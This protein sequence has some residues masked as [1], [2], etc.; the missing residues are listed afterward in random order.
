MWFAGNDLNAGLGGDIFYQNTATSLLVSFEGVQFHNGGAGGGEINAQVEVFPDGT[1]NTCWSTGDLD[2]NTIIAGAGGNTPGTVTFPPPGAPFTDAAPPSETATYPTNQCRCFRQTAIGGANGD[3][4]FIRWEHKHHDSFHGECDLVLVNAQSAHSK[5]EVAVHLRT[6]IR[7]E[8]YS[9]I[10]AIGIAIGN[11]RIEIEDKKFKVNGKELDSSVK[12][13]LTLTEEVQNENGEARH[14]ITIRKVAKKLARSKKR[15]QEYT[16]DWGTGSHLFVTVMD[17]FLNVEVVGNLE[18][19]GTSSGLMGEYGTGQML[20]RQGN[21]MSLSNMTAYGMEWQVRPDEDVV[22]FSTERAPQWPQR[23]RM[24]KF[25]I[26]DVV[27]RNLR[28]EAGKKLREKAEKA[29][30]GADDVDNCIE[31]VVATGQEGLAETYFY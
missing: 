11:H 23:C 26:D 13:P 30:A 3:P 22:I 18:D 24:P 21:P 2:G 8:E 20:D 5:Y 31:D 17:I 14:P 16:I 28:G 19:F 15:K 4:H 6:K 12:F 9:L 10:Q 1:V 27:A 7:K 29:C 25:N